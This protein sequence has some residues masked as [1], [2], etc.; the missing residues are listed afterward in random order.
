MVRW[1]SLLPS[2]DQGRVVSVV[3][4]LKSVLE[5]TA[6]LPLVWFPSVDVAEKD[7]V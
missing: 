5:V 7:M 2:L 3:P 1:A 6:E 4:Q